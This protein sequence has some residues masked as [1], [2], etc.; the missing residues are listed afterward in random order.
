MNTTQYF[1]KFI[2]DKN[3]T[4]AKAETETDAKILMQ[5]QYEPTTPEFYQW[6]IENTTRIDQAKYN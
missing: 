2:S 1:V 3:V 5:N 6:V 4:I